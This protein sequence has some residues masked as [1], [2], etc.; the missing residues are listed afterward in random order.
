LRA[1]VWKNRQNI[2]V[3]TAMN[4]SPAEGNICDGHENTLIEATVKDYMSNRPLVPSLW[5]VDS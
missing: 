4:H 1:I 5:A 2:S 3:L